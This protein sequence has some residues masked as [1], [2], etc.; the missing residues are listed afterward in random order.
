MKMPRPFFLFAA[1]SNAGEG[2]AN[3]LDLEAGVVA[4]V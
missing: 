1:E 2:R 4:H 3:P